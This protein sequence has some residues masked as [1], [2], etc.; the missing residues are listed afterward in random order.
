MP[1][2]VDDDGGG[3]GDRNG[4]LTSRSS[5]RGSEDR[6]Q[7]SGS[8]TDRD[9]DREARGPRD[10]WEVRAE[11]V[12]VATCDGPTRMLVLALSAEHLS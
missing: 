9:R 4:A 2:N 8:Y 5:W 11:L 12:L 10:G 6:M 7:G 3:R 1:S